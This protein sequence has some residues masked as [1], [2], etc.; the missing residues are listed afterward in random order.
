M[1]L[2]LLA[3]QLY[4][5]ATIA[6]LD[7][8]NYRPRMTRDELTAKMQG[9]IDLCRRLAAGTIDQRTAEALRLM[10]DEGER[11]LAQLKAEQNIIPQ[12]PQQ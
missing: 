4:E 8:P 10:A 2:G 5:R 7:R 11:D 12:T 1:A 3:L 6:D 9:R